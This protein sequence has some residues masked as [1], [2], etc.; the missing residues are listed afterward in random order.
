VKGETEKVTCIIQVPYKMVNLPL[1]QS[2]VSNYNELK[3]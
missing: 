3:A 2:V 1:Q